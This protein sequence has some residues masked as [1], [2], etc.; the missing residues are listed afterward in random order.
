MSLVQRKL[1]EHMK[2]N[3]DLADDSVPLDPQV[4]NASAFGTKRRKGGVLAPGGGPGAPGAP[5]V[6]GN[7]NSSASA[8]PNNG[9]SVAIQDLDNPYIKQ[10]L[11]RV[12]SRVEEQRRLL[13][14]LFGV[15]VW[16]LVRSVLD[17]VV[18]PKIALA[19]DPAAA[20]AWFQ[21]ILYALLGTNAA[22]SLYR[23]AKPVDKCLDLPLTAKQRELVGL[24]PLP[25]AE[26]EE[27]VPQ[28]AVETVAQTPVQIK[29]ED[30]D[31]RKL[32]I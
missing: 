32:N 19:Y 20:V 3:G 24:P 28:A 21:W 9:P 16:R 8:S 18:A 6:I 1:R 26:E 12:V 31:I 13:G 17:S 30:L 7:G 27:W 14:T 5:G 22:I 4:L 23:L 2:Q 11:A 10:A 29:L 15:L 25:Q